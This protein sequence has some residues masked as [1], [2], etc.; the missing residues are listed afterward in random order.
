MRVALYGGTG[1]VGCYLVEHLRAAGHDVS[2][3]VRPGSEDKVPGATGCRVVSGDIGDEAAVAATLAD[4]DAAIYNI[5]LLREFPSR[6]VTFEAMHY[7]GAKRAIDAARAADVNRFVLMSANG[8]KPDGTAYQR[9]KYRA[10]QY[11][12]AS[13]LDYTIFRPSVLF[14]DPR[15]RME[16][17]TQLRDQMILPPLP[18]PAFYDGWLP[19]GPSFRMSPIHADDV[20]E[21]FV[22]ALASPATLG[23]TYVLCGPEAVAWPEIIR[24]IAAA[25]GRRK[26][27]LPAPVAPLKIVA[28]LFGRFEFFPVTRDQLTMLVE[29]NTGDS[30]GLFE[31]LGIRPKA[32]EAANLGYLA[33]R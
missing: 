24:R 18:A 11:L 32:F 1:F 25:C 28:A 8:A 19:G 30:T 5:G 15:G 22:R 33:S 7:D 13:G 23:Q 2:L 29:G 10:D 26:I 27:I 21:S 16:F 6:G 14:G 31:L 3:L 9:T 20:A 17:C 12:A 4:C